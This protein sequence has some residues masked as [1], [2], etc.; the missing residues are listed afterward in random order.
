MEGFCKVS[1]GMFSLINI[2]CFL[3]HDSIHNIP[4]THCKSRSIFEIKF[5]Y[6]LLCYI[7]NLYEKLSVKFHL[8]CFY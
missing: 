3:K 5:K 7:L 2:Q 1:S 8:E 4:L 6:M